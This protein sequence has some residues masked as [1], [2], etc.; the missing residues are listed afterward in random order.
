[1][2]KGSPWIV[3]LFSFAC[4]LLLFEFLKSKSPFVQ[5][6]QLDHIENIDTWICFYQNL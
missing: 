2:K 1:M 6:S 4:N 5:F 3:N